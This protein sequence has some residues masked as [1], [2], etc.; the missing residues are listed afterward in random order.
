MKEN[1]VF[2]GVEPTISHG[3]LN[4]NLNKHPQHS[5]AALTF[6]AELMEYIVQ[7]KVGVLTLIEQINSSFSLLLV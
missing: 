5:C 3:R 2:L 1:Q 6:V 4:L 7:G